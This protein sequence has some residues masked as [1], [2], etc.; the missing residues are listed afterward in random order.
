MSEPCWYE[1]LDEVQFLGLCPTEDGEAGYEGFVATLE[2]AFRI[3]QAFQNVT[4]THFV[5]VKQKKSGM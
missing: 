2:D 4:D 5:V 1:G 3:I